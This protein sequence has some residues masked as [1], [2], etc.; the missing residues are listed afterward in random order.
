[1]VMS[2]TLFGQALRRWRLARRLSQLELASRAE[3]PSRHLSFLETGRSRPSREMVL[4]LAEAL[5]LPLGERN[6]LLQA[7]GF[8][9]S[10][11]QRALSDDALA[12]IRFVIDRVLASHAPFP[13]FVLD[14]WYDVLGA[15]LGARRLFLGGQSID[16]DDPPNLLDLLLGPMRALLLNWDDHVHDAISRLRRDVADAPDDERLHTMLARLEAVPHVPSETLDPAPV[17]TSRARVGN[18][19]LTTLSTLV[20]F[21]GVRDVTV[22]GLHLELIFPADPT[23]EAFLRQLGEAVAE[24]SLQRPNGLNNDRSGSSP[25]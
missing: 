2:H 3:T 13:G 5:E 8:L 6:G 16:P 25:S 14:R 9:P 11:P 12:P 22:D 20:R 23:T 24:V 4:R 7:A 19:T 15:N 1:M 17:L 10:F 18:V 21:G